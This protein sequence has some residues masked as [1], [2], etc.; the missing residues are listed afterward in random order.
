MFA[1]F[2]TRKIIFTVQSEMPTFVKQYRVG[3]KAYK[4]DLYKIARKMIKEGKP[5]IP[6]YPQN[7]PFS[8]MA[9]NAVVNAVREELERLQRESEP[10]KVSADAAEKGCFLKPI[11]PALSA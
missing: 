2:Y 10:V 1:N 7:R 9:V 8:D 6:G 11:K 3:G 4:T 5:F